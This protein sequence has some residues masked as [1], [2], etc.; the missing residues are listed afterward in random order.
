[1]DIEWNKSLQ[2]APYG[3]ELLVKNELMDR[4]T[5][6]YRGYY[7]GFYVTDPSGNN[8]QRIVDGQLVCPT[9][10]CFY[11]REKHKDIDLWE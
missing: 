11:D 7:N 9:M 8:F 4:P 1:M 2:D 3:V 5:V 6:A 10:W